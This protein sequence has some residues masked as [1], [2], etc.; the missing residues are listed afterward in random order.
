MS[1]THSPA[2]PATILREDVLPALRLTVEE[3]AMQLG[4]SADS[5]A[6]VLN[7]EAPIT[8]ELAVRIE[9]WLGADRGG[10]AEHWL[11]MQLQYDLWHARNQDV[12]GVQRAPDEIREGRNSN[13][14]S[15][16]PRRK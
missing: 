8:A 6:R 14:E 7:E 1:Q 11:R 4:V 15:D 12:S 9:A 2:H 3:V 5:L 10:D 13:V 16:L